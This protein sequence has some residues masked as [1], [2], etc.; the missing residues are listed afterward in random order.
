MVV[1]R[2]TTVI[3]SSK[4][5]VFGSRFRLRCAPRLNLSSRAARCCALFEMV[6]CGRCAEDAPAGCLRTPK[7]CGKCCRPPCG[8]NIH[9]RRHHPRGKR[10]RVSKE[11]TWRK[12]W[13]RAQANVVVMWRNPPL[14]RYMLETG[15][16]F[17]SIRL[18]LMREILALIR[19]RSVEDEE[20]PVAVAV[21]MPPREREE[22]VEQLKQEV[23]EDTDLQETLEAALVTDEEVDSEDVE[24][25]ETSDVAPVRGEKRASSSCS[26]PGPPEPPLK[27]IRVASPAEETS[28]PSSSSAPA[29]RTPVWNP[30]GLPVLDKKGKECSH[31]RRRTP[32]FHTITWKKKE[33]PPVEQRA[34]SYTTAEQVLTAW[35]KV[36]PG[37]LESFSSIE[38]RTYPWSAKGGDTDQAISNM[39]AWGVYIYC[40]LKDWVPRPRGDI[41]ITA[42]R[43]SSYREVLDDV[44]HASSMYSVHKSVLDG[45]HPGPIPGKGGR[46]GLYCFRPV[47]AY[48]ACSSSGYAVYSWIGGSF[49][50]SPR[51]DIAAEVYRAGEEGIGKISVGGEQIALQPGMYF[52]RGVYFHLVTRED[53]ARGLPTWVQ[54]D[55]WI[56]EHE[57]AVE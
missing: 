2:G 48:A 54:W 5:A 25:L 39:H 11:E 29:F 9:G 18:M 45:L 46:T 55:D 12:A 35:L 34:L 24:A 31:Y 23:G 17:G 38:V 47:G 20:T 44:I 28:M 6:K 30:Q 26:L 13:N 41:D 50:A 1:T 43:S 14:R 57:L 42:S 33:P 22:F 51:Y 19:D 10:G 40:K 36:R 16:T 53:A 4:H 7:L 8:D 21:A 49:L 37:L 32:P 15:A 52:L 27:R 3:V 56:P